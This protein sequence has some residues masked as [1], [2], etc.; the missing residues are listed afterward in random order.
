MTQTDS[1]FT[2]ILTKG[3]ARGL[4]Q[5]INDLG[6]RLRQSGVPLMRLRFGMRATHPLSVAF[7]YIWEHDGAPVAE[8]T[9][10]HGLETRAAYVGSPMEILDRQRIPYRKSLRDP[11]TEADHGILHELQMRG[12]TD[13]LGL[14]VHFIE[15]IG[16]ILIFVCDGPEGFTPEHIELFGAI[17]DALAPVA[18]AHSNYRFARAIATS[19]LGPRTGQRVLDG[20]ITRGDIETIKAAVLFGDI[21]GW[22]ALNA[23]RPAQEALE[24]ANRYFDVMSEAV[25]RHEGEILKFTGDGVLAVFPADGTDVGRARACVQALSAAQAAHQIA[26]Q[27]ELPVPFG[28]GIH[29]GA[30]LYGN[31]GAKE[32]LDFT[33][34]GQAVNIAARIEAFCGR[35]AAPI[36]VSD[37]VAQ[38]VA[39][40]LRPVASKE[41]KGVSDPMLLHTPANS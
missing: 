18:E 34:L 14:P 30:V 28:V 27:A 36:L 11:L 16:G 38:V 29:Y 1:H 6:P 3:R 25:D 2:W 26:Q 32:R 13:Y 20:Q 12:A 41:I 7:S 9:A 4:R 5:L 35:L 21:R 24:V 31:V 8:T 40:P 17:A 19:Y 37:D 39:T 33:V 10:P 15:G 22:T 23:T